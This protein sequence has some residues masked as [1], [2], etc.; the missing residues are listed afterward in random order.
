MRNFETVI[1][2]TS[3]DT[4]SSIQRFHQQ[5]HV[6]ESDESAENCNSTSTPFQR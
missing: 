4:F 3:N 2:S 5:N 1:V 6:S